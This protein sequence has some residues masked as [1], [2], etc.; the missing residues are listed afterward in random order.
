M[1]N[2]GFYEYTGGGQRAYFP[3]VPARDMTEAEWRALTPEQRHDVR[4]LYEHRTAVPFGKLPDQLKA[5]LAERDAEMETRA[6]ADK[7]R[8]TARAAKPKPTPRATP[9][10]PPESP[11]EP[12]AAEVNNEAPPESGASAFG[13]G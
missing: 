13:E 8:P 12:P 3:G 10:P 11:P 9:A 4:D 2:H 5:A 1:A 6:K 7:P